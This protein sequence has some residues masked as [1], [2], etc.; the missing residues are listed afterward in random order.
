MF[1]KSTEMIIHLKK[2]EAKI[3]FKN[4]QMVNQIRKIELFPQGKKIEI[5]R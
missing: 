3:L 1:M 4:K 5:K 2:I